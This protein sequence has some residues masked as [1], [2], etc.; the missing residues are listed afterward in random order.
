MNEN[1]W[2]EELD[3]DVDDG[4]GRV[5]PA[6]LCNQLGILASQLYEMSQTVDAI[7]DII[8]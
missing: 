2:E 5:V 8:S 7:K 6:E 1:V 4:G 3:D